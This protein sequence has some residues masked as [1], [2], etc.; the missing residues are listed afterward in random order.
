VLEIAMLASKALF[1]AAGCCAGVRLAQIARRE[2]GLPLHAWASA[3][4][5]AG[6][7]GLLG[8]G[9][10][11]V[12]AEGSPAAARALMLA[13]DALSRLVILGLTLFIWRVFGGGTGPR[14]GLLAALVALQAVNWVHAFGLQRWPEPTP[15]L[16]RFEN[17]I[18]LALPF[19]WSAVESR[20]AHA[21]SR[22]QLAL[23]LTDA[24]TA[25][26]LLIWCLACACF[27][28]IGFAA[29]AGAVTPADSP[30]AAPLTL[31]Q[32]ALFAATAA[33]VTL[34]FFPPRAYVRR[35]AA[36]APR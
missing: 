30:L 7:F 19:V 15:P 27:A 13:S 1:A 14:S 12:V 36:A 6:G 10:G 20:L 9:L 34:A 29:A 16:L 24:L 31:L 33:M 35:L 22:K 4:V 28:C 3:L 2:G 21:R 23:G 18:V 11:P 17:Q 8:F 5:F 26:R 32:A 25:N